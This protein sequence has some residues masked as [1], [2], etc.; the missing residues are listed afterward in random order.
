VT[1]DQP[2]PLPIRVR[3]GAGEGAES[4]IRR[5]ARANH[6]KPSYLRR[7]LATPEGSYG[8]VRPDQLAAVTGRS[9]N[10]LLHALPDLVGR[11]R[12]HGTRRQTEDKKRRNQARRQTLFATIRQDATAGL[13]RRALERKHHVGRRTIVK[14]L[15]SETPPPRKKIDRRPAALHGL[16][17]HIDAMIE[18]NPAVAVKDVW[19]HLADDHDTTVSYGAVRAYVTRH[20]AE[21]EQDPLTDSGPKLPG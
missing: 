13:S 4:Y 15:V 8:P 11:P 6:L 5:L 3:P 17:H 19:T 1:A 7:Y 20:K 2:R 10:A 9:L 18:K 16:H 21:F 12:R 14:A